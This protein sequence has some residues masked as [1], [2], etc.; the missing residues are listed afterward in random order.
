[1]NDLD[2]WTEIEKLAHL[3]KIPAEKL[4]FLRTLPL[5]D[6]RTLN[7][8]ISD[9]LL[10]D[11][12]DIWAKLASVAKITPN[13]LNAQIAK[14]ILGPN[15]TANLAYHIDPKQAAA[16]VSSFSTDFLAEVAENLVPARAQSLI[17][18]IPMQTLSSLT[19]TMVK[20]QKYFTMGAFVDFMDHDKILTLSKEIPDSESLLRVGLY[21]QNKA[22]VAGLADGFSDEKILDLIETAQ[23]RDLWGA[24]IGLLAHF[25]EAQHIRLAR[26]AV[27]VS[28]EA[29]LG[30]V[31]FAIE[32]DA[33]V[34]LFAF[35]K[36]MTDE[37]HA[38]MATIVARLDSE[39]L[40]KIIHAAD[41]SGEL[42]TALHIANHLAERDVERLASMSH[43]FDDNLLKNVISTA[44]GE[45]LTPFA[46]RLLGQ[47]PDSE[48]P[49]AERIARQLPRKMIEDAQAELDQSYFKA[50]LTWLKSL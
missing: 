26:L 37:M 31:P 39:S 44:H 48:I 33:L 27:K 11:A 17:R 13:F 1:M 5:N 49:R 3:L 8:A 38:H 46:L 41:T 10:H 20:Q 9:R 25:S 40:A 15:I 32:H 12:S 18:A 30:M 35:L 28:V 47:L 23:R 43:R 16:M 2:Q 36:H 29:L 4:S 42:I 19:R 22:H 50:R 45:G 7:G 6:F 21:T 34:H 24:L 14:S